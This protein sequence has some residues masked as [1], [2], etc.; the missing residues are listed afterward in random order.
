MD[1]DRAF[2][3]C[4]FQI[5]VGVFGQIGPWKA[6]VNESGFHGVIIQGAADVNTGFRRKKVVRIRH[7]RKHSSIFIPI[8]LIKVDKIGGRSDIAGITGGVKSDGAQHHSL[9]DRRI[10]W[11]VSAIFFGDI[12]AGGI[13]I[14]M[15]AGIHQCQRA[16]VEGRVRRRV[17]SVQRIMNRS[18]A[19]RID[20]Q[21]NRVFIK[22]T[23]L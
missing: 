13:A 20:L 1:I 7:E 16:A 2:S 8:L 17:A 14:G 18:A 6:V 22:I 12:S 5:I 11:Q 4:A 9:I 10:R 3:F 19:G 23:W 15:R 21:R